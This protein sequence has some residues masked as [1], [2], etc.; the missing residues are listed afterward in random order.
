MSQLFPAT[1]STKVFSPKTPRSWTSSR[2]LVKILSLGVRRLICVR[3]DQ[4]P[5][6]VQH[7]ARAAIGGRMSLPN[8][9]RQTL[10]DADVE[11]V[12]RRV[13]NGA[14][15]RGVALGPSDQV[16]KLFAAGII[17]TD[18]NGCA[19]RRHARG[20]AIVES[21]YPAVIAV[22]FNGDLEPCE[23]HAEACGAHGNHGRAA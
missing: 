18:L 2:R 21:Q 11:R 9:L 6:C 19:E 1:P 12:C 8:L 10:H 15:D 3:R 23:I 5:R 13:S 16:C 7:R 4:A 14:S 22:A 17:R 20:N